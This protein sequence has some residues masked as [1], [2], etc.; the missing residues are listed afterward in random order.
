MYNRF[1]SGLHPRENVM[2]T[3]S[4]AKDHSSSLEDHVHLLE[5]VSYFL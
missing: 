2:D 3:V 1:E 5:K 4:A